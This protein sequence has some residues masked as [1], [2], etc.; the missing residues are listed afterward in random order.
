MIFPFKWPSWSGNKT[1]TDV[2]CPECKAKNTIMVAGTLNPE[3]CCSY[4]CEVCNNYFRISNQVHVV[5]LGDTTDLR[6]VE[7]THAGSNPALDIF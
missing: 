4:Y 3:G 6:S 7:E 1:K 5:K 2:L